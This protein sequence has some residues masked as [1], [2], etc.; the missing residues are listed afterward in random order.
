MSL[1]LLPEAVPT[2]AELTDWPVICRFTKTMSPVWLVD[3]TVQVNL[4]LDV[5]PSLM[6]CS[7]LPIC[8]SVA[9]GLVTLG[10][11]VVEFPMR[12]MIIMNCSLFVLFVTV[13]FQSNVRSEEH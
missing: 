2:G 5:S 9:A 3:S 13:R 12:I 11:E 7:I 6:N 1:N 10:E 8:G 4:M